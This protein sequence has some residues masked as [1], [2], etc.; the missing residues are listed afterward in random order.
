M[1][2]NYKRVL[3]FTPRAAC[4]RFSKA[5]IGATVGTPRYIVPRISRETVRAH[6][7]DLTDLDGWCRGKTL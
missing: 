3:V 5:R 6:C 4:F 2:I 1:N 7:A